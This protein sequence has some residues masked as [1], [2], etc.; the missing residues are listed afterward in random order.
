MNWEIKQRTKQNMKT[1][2]ENEVVSIDG[3]K[4]VR[5]SKKTEVG[6]VVFLWYDFDDSDLLLSWEIAN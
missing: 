6:G 2:L 3:R 1:H 5:R 4:G